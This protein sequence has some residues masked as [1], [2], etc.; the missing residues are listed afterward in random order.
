VVVYFTKKDDSVLA[1]PYKK[2]REAVRNPTPPSDKDTYTPPAMAGGHTVTVREN[3]EKR[4]GTRVFALPTLAEVYV[5]PGSLSLSS[6]NDLSVAAYHEIGHDVTGMSN[7][8]LHPHGGLF[9][10][11]HSIGAVVA[12]KTATTENIQ[13]LKD[14]LGKQDNPQYLLTP[15]MKWSRV[16]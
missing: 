9:D 15:E 16:K 13:L 14:H 4:S 6:V 10:S 3:Q 2:A 1:G 8:E 5:D 11:H 7:A 12:T